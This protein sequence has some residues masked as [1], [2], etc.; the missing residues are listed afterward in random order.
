MSTYERFSSQTYSEFMKELSKIG[1][2]TSQMADK[3]SSMIKMR[4][5]IVHQ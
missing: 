5:I 4:K 3:A 1:V 2:I